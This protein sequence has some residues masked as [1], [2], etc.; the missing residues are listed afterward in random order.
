MNNAALQTLARHA[1]RQR[2]DMQCD[3]QAVLD[4]VAEC[5]SLRSRL[6]STYRAHKCRAAANNVAEFDSVHP[7]RAGSLLRAAR[8]RAKLTQPELS[9]RAGVSVTQ[10]SRIEVT[11]GAGWATMVNLLEAAGYDVLIQPRGDQ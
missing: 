5:V 6:R 1:K 4:L 8:K 10:I 9:S 2:K 7:T 11:Q 3:P